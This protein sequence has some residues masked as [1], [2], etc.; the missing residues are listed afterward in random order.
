[1]KFWKNTST[2]DKFVPE[3][4]DTVDAAEADIAVIGG[5]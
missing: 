5:K 4:L 1:M 3:L 2:L